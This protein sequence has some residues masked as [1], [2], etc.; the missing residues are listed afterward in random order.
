MIEASRAVF[1]ATPI[2]DVTYQIQQPN[3]ARLCR[4]L[5]SLRRL[6]AKFEAAASL[7]AS[8]RGCA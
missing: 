2:F 3:D 1:S 8:E 5:A 6:P 7:V 4:T